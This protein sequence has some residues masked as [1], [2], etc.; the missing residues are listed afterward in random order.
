MLR[1]RMMATAK[2]KAKVKV[3]EDKRGACFGGY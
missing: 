1:R 2:A 3:K